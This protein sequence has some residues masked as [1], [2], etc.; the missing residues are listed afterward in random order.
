MIIGPNGGWALLRILFAL[1]LSKYRLFPSPGTPGEPSLSSSGSFGTMGGGHLLYC[2]IF[3]CSTLSR[4]A[5]GLDYEL[6]ELRGFSTQ[7]FSPAERPFA[8]AYFFKLGCLTVIQASTWT[9]KTTTFFINSC[10]FAL[11]TPPAELYSES[12]RFVLQI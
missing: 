3:H 8:T 5:G 1:A 7:R 12:L 2:S 4:S 9:A 10:A 11:V 6:S